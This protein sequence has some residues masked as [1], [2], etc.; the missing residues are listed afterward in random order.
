MVYKLCERTDFEIILTGGLVRN[1]DRAIWDEMTA[2]FLRRFRVDFGIFGV[3]SLTDDGKLLDYHYR[4]AQ[5]SRAAMEIARVKL[6]GFD[7]SKLNASA[8]MPFADVA[9]VD[10]IFTDKA[11]APDLARLIGENGVDLHIA[12]MPPD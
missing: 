7:H 3:G 2:D 4:D 9:E 10:A 8:L 1:R 6:V 5:A 12:D 11:L